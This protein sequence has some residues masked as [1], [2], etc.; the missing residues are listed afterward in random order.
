MPVSD[1]AFEK[2]GEKKVSMEPLL[3]LWLPVGDVYINLS[4]L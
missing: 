3:S 2:Q 4:S 1:A